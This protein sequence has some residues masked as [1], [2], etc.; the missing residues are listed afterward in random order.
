[1]AEFKSA[2]ISKKSIK[3][4]IT[5]FKDKVNSTIEEADNALLEL[6]ENK[7][8]AFHKEL[9]NIF[10]SLFLHCDDKE[11]DD[12]IAERENVIETLDEISLV[13]K[14]KLL[15]DSSTNKKPS[16]T[17]ISKDISIAEIKLP[18][19]SLPIFSGKI[20]EW[21]E[22]EDLFTAAVHNNA[23]LSNAQK[24]QYLKG[25]CKADALDI[26]HSISIS[27]VNYD[28]A[29]NLLVERYSNKRDLI[30][31]VIKKLLYLPQ[32][33]DSATSL[34]RYVDS[35]NECLRSLEALNQKVTD[36]SDTLIL[37][38]LVEKLD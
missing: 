37:Y 19:L 7:I 18:T 26:I 8:V 1:M 25:S 24:L 10:D 9:N 30:N 33:V 17:A 22:F 13:I 34:L 12:F 16:D 2:K 27:D 29:W 6:Y 4:N 23:N 38:V 15:K 28:I 35:I 32:T 36:F 5:K 14:R 31:A 21:I 11:I 3:S 20:D